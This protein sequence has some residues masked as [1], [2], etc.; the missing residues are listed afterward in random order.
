[1]NRRASGFGDRIDARRQRLDAHAG[2]RLLLARALLVERRAVDAVRKP[3]HH[4]RPIGDG[5]QDERRHLR[6]VAEQIALGELAVRPEDLREVGDAEPLAVGQLDRAVAAG[7]LERAQLIDDRVDRGTMR[8]ILADR[9]SR[10]WRAACAAS[11]DA[12]L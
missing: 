7:V 9:A 10:S 4:Q 8:R 5:G 11:F 6:V 12:A 2:R 1:M 3:L